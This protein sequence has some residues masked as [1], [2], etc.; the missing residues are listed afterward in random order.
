MKQTETLP[1]IQAAFSTA[2]IMSQEL[3]LK[4]LKGEI[5]WEDER[6]QFFIPIALKFT[7]FEWLKLI[8]EHNCIE[9]DEAIIKNFLDYVESLMEINSRTLHS[10]FEP[11][12]K[13]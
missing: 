10:Y 5:D 1:D 9:E 4:L 3:Q 2:K 7:D 13:E 8:A 6:V 12:Y 11:N